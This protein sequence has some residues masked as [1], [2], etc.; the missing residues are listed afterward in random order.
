MKK[1]GQKRGGGKA[2]GSGTSG[3]R[4]SWSDENGNGVLADTEEEEVDME[5]IRW[6]VMPPNP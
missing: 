3:R 5:T 1:G 2:D 6:Q 4:L